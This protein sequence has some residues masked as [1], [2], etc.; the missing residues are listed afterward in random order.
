[1]NLQHRIYLIIT[2]LLFIGCEKQ[3][4]FLDK[5]PNDALIVPT[6]LNDFKLLLNNEQLFN[7]NDPSLGVISGEDFYISNDIWLS[8]TTIE[9]NT[10]IWAS[11]IYQS[12]KT[13]SDWAQPYNAIYEA[14]YILEGLAKMI[15][16]PSQVTEYN[17]YKGQAMFYR[18]WNFYNLV[19][20]YAPPYDSTTANSDL[21]ILLRLSSDFNIK[22]KRA[23]VKDSYTKIISDLT[24]A[25]SLLPAATEHKTTQ[26]TSITANAMLARVYLAMGKYDLAFKYSDA[27][28]NQNSKLIDFNTLDASAY[29][30]SNGFVVEDIFHNSLTGYN[31]TYYGEP[32]VDSILYASYDENDLRKSVYF[33]LSDYGVI[34]FKGSYDYYGYEYTGLAIDEMYLIRA[35]CYARAG[36][37]QAAI[38]DLNTLLITRWKTGTFIP[39]TASSSDDALIQVL[40]ER[41]KELVFRGLRWTDLRR[42]NK[43]DRFKTTLTR[44]IN[45]HSY[46]LPPNDKK[47][48]LPI[49]DDEIRL[50][51][52]PQNER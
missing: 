12:K 4:E 50:N 33:G 2:L 44:I 15:P 49:P 48:V 16:S 5:K 31:I 3:N 13:Y 52:I 24:T 17:T 43:E 32:E 38:N 45:S 30:I 26:A 35:E 29:P 27:T 9:Q 51:E 11:D 36:N 46:T 23:S 47:Y 14:N 28:L 37:T 21:G 42:L 10:Y 39:Y 20:T 19:Q 1:M 22:Y 7:T 25:L 40:Q 6:T 41:R 34:S 8:A 18:A